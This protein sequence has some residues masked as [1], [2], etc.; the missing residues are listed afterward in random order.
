MQIP[1]PAY[2]DAV[3]SGKAVVHVSGVKAFTEHSIVLQNWET[4][5]ADVA[6][7]ATGYKQDFPFLDHAVKE[8]LVHDSDGL[9]LYRHILHPEIPGLAFIGP[10]V[11]TYLSS[12]TFSL[13]AAWIARM[14]SKEMVVPSTSAMWKSIEKAK[15]VGRSRLPQDPKRSTALNARTIKYHDLLCRDMGWEPRRKGLLGMFLDYFTPAYPRT[16]K[17]IVDG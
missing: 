5:D 16:Y 15:G 13:Q 3:K 1:K 4:I 7:M 10:N 12:C 17:H 11:S 6:V 2:Y 14:L 8:K 9:W